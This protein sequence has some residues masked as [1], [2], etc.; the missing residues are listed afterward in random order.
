MKRSLAC[1]ALLG[2]LFAELPA[3]AAGF[4]VFTNASDLIMPPEPPRRLPPGTPPPPPRPPVVIVPP[5][6]MPPIHALAPI[7]IAYHKVTARVA[8]QVAITTIEQEFYN[9][10]GRAHV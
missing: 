1:L 2:L 3:L 9:Q 10:I 8:D 5:R 6:P 4:I 7:E